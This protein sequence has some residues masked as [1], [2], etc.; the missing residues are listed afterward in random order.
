MAQARIETIKQTEEVGLFTIRFEGDSV[1]EFEKFANKFK[2]DAKRQTDL[3][4]ILNALNKMLENGATLER[5]FRPEGKMRDN[6]VALPT[7]RT[8][9]RLYCLRM[10]DSVLI[11][12]NGGEKNTKTYEES[13]ELNGYV[14]SL[15]KLDEL[16]KQ[17]IASGSVVIEK[18]NI[19]GADEKTFDL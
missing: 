8:S 7:F 14:I 5:Y 6:I 9:L 18:A 17:E 13:A 11:V 19:V 16:L 2:D 12:G 10:S 15:Q 3:Q 4:M 1:T